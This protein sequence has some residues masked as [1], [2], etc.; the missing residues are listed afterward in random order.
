MEPGV[1]RI[2]PGWGHTGLADAVGDGLGC[3]AAFVGCVAVVP[4]GC[5]VVVGCAV[6]V[7]VC[8]VGQEGWQD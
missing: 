2:V 1:V 3:V 5:V 4:V 7:V 6:V 8:G